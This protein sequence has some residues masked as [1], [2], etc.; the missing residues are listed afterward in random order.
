MRVRDKLINE[1]RFSRSLRNI[2]RIN[3]RQYPRISVMAGNP[4]PTAIIASARDCDGVDLMAA[5]PSTGRLLPALPL[6]LIASTTGRRRGPFSPVDPYRLR[7]RQTSSRQG[8]IT[9]PGNAPRSVHAACRLHGAERPNPFSFRCQSPMPAKATCRT[10]QLTSIAT[11]GRGGASRGPRTSR[12]NAGV[13]APVG[14]M[15]CS[16]RAEA[17]GEERFLGKRPGDG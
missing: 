3:I 17:G 12:V 16:S 4:W 15:R 8:V 10:A 14:Q 6:H 7:Q 13:D 11:R 5:A 1:A 9:S 2:Q